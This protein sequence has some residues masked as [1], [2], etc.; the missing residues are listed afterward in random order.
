MA[1]FAQQYP[2]RTGSNPTIG[3]ANCG[4]LVLMG[5]VGDQRI[6]PSYCTTLSDAEV[7]EPVEFVA[8]DM[9]NR[10]PALKAVTGMLDAMLGD[11]GV[12]N[13][14]LATDQYWTTK[15]RVACGAFG[16]AVKRTAYWR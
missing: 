5:K 15:L 13:C 16:R 2:T 7:T 6:V 12:S 10:V 8:K 9:V 4:Q 1:R 11:R 14:T 3:D